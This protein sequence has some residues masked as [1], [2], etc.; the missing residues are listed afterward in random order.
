MKK[1]LVL[2][3]LVLAVLSLIAINP[4]FSQQAP[5]KQATP[6]VAVKQETPKTAGLTIERMV[7]GTGIE[8][9]ELVGASDKFPAATE[10][11][12]CFIEAKNIDEDTT[13]TAVWSYEGK[14]L[15]KYDLKLQKSSRWRTNANKNLNGMKGNWQVEVK[16]VKGNTLKSATFKVE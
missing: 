13:I 15:S 11:V 8:N 10:K 14:E 16:D 12:F 2:S 7:V 3:V 9:K 1:H 4:A 6:T 5:A